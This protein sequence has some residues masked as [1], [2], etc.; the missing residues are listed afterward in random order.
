MDSRDS[1]LRMEALCY[2]G[3]KRTKVCSLHLKREDSR[4]YLNGRIPE[5]WFCCKFALSVLFPRKGNHPRERMNVPSRFSSIRHTSV[6]ESF[7]TRPNVLADV[8]TVFTILCSTSLSRAIKVTV[9]G[10]P[11]LVYLETLRQVVKKDHAQGQIPECSN[12]CTL[13]RCQN[14]FPSSYLSCSRHGF[15]GNACTIN[16][17]LLLLYFIHTRH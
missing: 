13:F 9:F 14:L 5:R 4:N 1:V 17:R 6:H 12:T 8:F 16:R 11:L 3:M 2:H 10:K 7:T 15:T